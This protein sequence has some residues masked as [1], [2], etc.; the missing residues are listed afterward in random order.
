M[1]GRDGPARKFPP[2]DCGRAGCDLASRDGRDGNGGRD[3]DCVLKCPDFC[4][5]GREW[6]RD[7]CRSWKRRDGRCLGCRCSKGRCCCRRSGWCCGCERCG[8]RERSSWA[9]RSERARRKSTCFLKLST[10]AI[11]TSTLSP[12]RITR[13]WRRPVS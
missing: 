3:C 9:L 4:C 7:C 11:C 13:R 1:C 5:C 12:R 8:G 6:P 2:P 10:L